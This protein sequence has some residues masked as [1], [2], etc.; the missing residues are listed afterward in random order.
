MDNQPLVGQLDGDDLQLDATVV[1]P[2]PRRARLLPDSPRRQPVSLDTGDRYPLT[3]PAT[4]RG[5]FS[6]AVR[7]SRICCP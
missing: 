7:V 4:L 3:C 6:P 5:Y 1:E 2:D